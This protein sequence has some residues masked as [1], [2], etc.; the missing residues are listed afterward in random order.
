[1]S[2]DREKVLKGLECCIRHGENAEVGCGRKNEC[3][4]EANGLKCW[5]DLNRDILTL[6]KEQE[7]ALYELWQLLKER[8]ED[9]ERLL[10]EQESR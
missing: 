4:Y 5:L 7:K 3:P 6:L 8:A 9:I 10:S 2:I 1:M